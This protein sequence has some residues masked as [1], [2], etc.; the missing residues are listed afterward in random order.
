MTLVVFWLSDYCFSNPFLLFPRHNSSHHHRH[1]HYRGRRDAAQQV[2]R[3]I[4][5]LFP[6]AVEFRTEDA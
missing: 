4:F 6:E 2:V 5:G 3:V 1:R